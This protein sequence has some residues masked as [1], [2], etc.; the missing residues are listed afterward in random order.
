[1]MDNFSSLTQEL[2]P[3][4]LTEVTGKEISR[5]KYLSSVSLGA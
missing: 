5:E 2:C 1:M 4:T 3:L